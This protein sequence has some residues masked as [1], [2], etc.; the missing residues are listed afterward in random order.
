MQL[1]P[2]LQ[3]FKAFSKNTNKT[4]I[5]SNFDYLKVHILYFSCDTSIILIF[6]IANPDQTK[7]SN[8][9]LHRSWLLLENSSRL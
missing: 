5:V 7:I 6:Y 1:G 9:T 4:L 2:G 8:N 3:I